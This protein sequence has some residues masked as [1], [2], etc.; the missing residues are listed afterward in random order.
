MYTNDTLL[1]DS[2][3]MNA[4]SDRKEGKT[5]NPGKP[6]PTDER[7]HDTRIRNR[8]KGYPENKPHQKEFHPS[9]KK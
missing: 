7:K 5:N 2:R 6:T 4:E 3:T 8:C 1:S 9:L